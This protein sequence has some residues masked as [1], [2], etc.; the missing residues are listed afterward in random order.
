MRGTLFAEKP[1]VATYRDILDQLTTAVAVVD[2]ASDRSFRISYLNQ[3]AQSLFGRSDARTIGVPLPKLMQDSHATPTVL[4]GVLDTGQPFTKREVSLYVADGLIRVNFS[5]SPLSEVRTAGGVRTS[6]PLHP[7]RPGRTP[8]LPTGD[9][10]QTCQGSR[11]RN[12]ESVGR[13]S[14]S[15]AA[16]GP[17]TG[18]RRSTRV[19]LGDHR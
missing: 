11:A 12:Q 14:G 9:D 15:G 8:R 3:S 18:E 17:A 7:Y 4:Q 2:A 16:A 19:H 13:H 5:I 10:A 6:R 1:P